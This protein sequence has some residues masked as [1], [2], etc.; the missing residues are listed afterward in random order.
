MLKIDT[1]LLLQSSRRPT[2]YVGRGNRVNWEKGV[3]YRVELSYT[4][5]GSGIE[6]LFCYTFKIAL[7]TYNR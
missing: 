5:A 2:F 7:R 6:A 1:D 4:S 3:Y